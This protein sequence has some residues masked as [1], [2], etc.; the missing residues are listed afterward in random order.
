MTD[1]SSYPQLN[2][3]FYFY[4]RRQFELHQRIDGAAIRIQNVDQPLVR[5]DLELLAALLIHVRRAVDRIDRLL[6]RQRD[7][8][9][10]DA[11]GRLHRPN[12]LFR[13]LVDQVMIVRF[14]FDSNFLHLFTRIGITA[15]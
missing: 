3:N 9:G 5:A 13:A 1:N 10:N 8:P 7:R 12:N 2:L 6:R 4:S 14:Q 15:S 11:A